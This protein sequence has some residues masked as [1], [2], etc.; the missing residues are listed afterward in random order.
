MDDRRSISIGTLNA[1]A[2]AFGDHS[3]ATGSMDAVPEQAYPSSDRAYP[4]SD[5][6]L[7]VVAADVE[8]QAV[9][10]AVTDV[11][12]VR[13]AVTYSARQSSFTL[14]RISRTDVRLA[15]VGAGTV[16]PDAAGPALP[17][18]LADVRPGFVILV[19]ICYGLKDSIQRMGD[20]LVANELRLAAHTKIGDR[21]IDRGGAVHPSPVLLNRFRSARAS[22]AGR[23]EVHFGPMISESVLVNSAGYREGLKARYPEA[24]G[25]EMEGAAV[26]A[27][28]IRARVEWG[29]V[30]AVCD[31]GFGKTDDHQRLAADNAAAFVTHMIATGGLDPV[32][33]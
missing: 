13:S 5:R 8:Y 14:G 15:Q 10:Q 31:W 32:P 29:L 16:T 17:D 22:W 20:V 3:S 26:Y 7:L 2:V 18:L 6:V 27:A 12:G 9:I 4:S 21:V 1:G 19:G 24:I 28:A 33:R 30:K 25:G 23:A 11:T